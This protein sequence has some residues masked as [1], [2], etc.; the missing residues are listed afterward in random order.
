MELIDI[1]LSDFNM[2]VIRFNDVCNLIDGELSILEDILN[3]SEIQ[4]EGTSCKLVVDSDSLTNSFKN[5]YKSLQYKRDLLCI[6]INDITKNVDKVK[7]IG[8]DFNR[9]EYDTCLARYEQYVLK[10]PRG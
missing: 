7:E 9:D 1:L 3:S 4:R 10:I 8:C 5:T 2:T 6:Y